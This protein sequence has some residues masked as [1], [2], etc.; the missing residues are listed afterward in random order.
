MLSCWFCTHQWS[1][2]LVTRT[3]CQESISGYSVFSRSAV[4]IRGFISAGLRDF[5]A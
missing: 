4:P 1:Q 3:G 2:A 5:L